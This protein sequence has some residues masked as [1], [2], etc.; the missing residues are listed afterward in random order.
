MISLALALPHDK[1]ASS[2]SEKKSVAVI[3]KIDGS[4]KVLSKK[5]IKK[6]QAKPGEALFEG[7]TLITS[8]DTTAVVELADH[9]S[10]VLN[11]G[12]ELS[13]IDTNT[14][15]QSAGEIYY[16]IKTRQS[17]QGLR[18]ET[19]FSIMGIKGTEFIVD[20]QGSGKIALNEGLVGI[21][22][23]SADFELHRQQVMAEYE[24]FID[25]QNSAFE[26]YK[27]EAEG[28]IV[29]YVKAFDLEAGK[30]LNFSAAENCK[31]ACASQVEEIEIPEALQ[32]RF[33]MYKEMIK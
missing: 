3:L 10:L 32:K 1:N 13:F 14:L 16:K 22:S 15:K 4:A 7:D 18:V 19:P 30:V 26:A 27:A 31:E 28:E 33:A 17:S 24:K 5:S 6:H 23:L 20:S 11:A 8:A 21:E 9:S 12:S 2:A 29:T 25:K